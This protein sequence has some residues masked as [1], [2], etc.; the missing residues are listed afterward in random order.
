MDIVDCLRR[1]RSAKST[2]LH[3]RGASPAGAGR[4]RAPR[5][6]RDRRRHRPAPAV[7]R[8]P[9]RRA[10]RGRAHP[11]ANSSTG[12]STL[13]RVLAG[14]W[15]RG[16]RQPARCPTAPHHDHAAEELPAARLAQGRA[17]LSQPVAAACTDDGLQAALEQVGLG[18]LI[19]RLDEVA[20]WDQVLSNGERQRLAI[21]RLLIHQPQVVILDD[22]LSA[23]EEP[24]QQTAAGAPAA[25]S[26]PRPPSSA[27]AS[28][29]RRRARTIA[30]LALERHATRRRA[31]A[32]GRAGAGHRNITYD[33]AREG[34]QG[35][36]A[37][38]KLNYWNQTWSL[39]EAQCPCDLHLVEYLEEKKAKDADRLPLR[40]RQ[41]PHRRPEARRERLQQ[42]RARHHRLAAGVR[43][44][45]RAADQEPAP[46]PHLQGLLRRH[47][48]ARRAGCCRSSTTSACSTSASSARPRTTATAR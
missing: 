48:P 18:A 28:G 1:H 2:P 4:R 11:A 36:D 22:A 20:R 33:Q 44:L 21:A 3:R 37:M 5:R 16:A 43:R 9:V 7:G 17:A 41:P 27:S 32:G 14:L 31:R 15:P 39:D 19:P 45:R 26:C 34:S 8:R 10:R 40:H 46:R 35:A 42:R 12:K 25:P 30:Q 6:F 24:A 23:L 13:V 29:R 47:L 38:T